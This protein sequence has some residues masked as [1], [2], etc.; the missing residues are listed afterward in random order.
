MRILCISDTVDPLVDSAGIRERFGDVDLVL[1]A[2]D[3]PL[4]YLSYVVTALNRPTLFVFGNH[5]LKDLPRYRPGS[6][7]PPRPVHEYDSD[8][9]ATYVG[10]KIRRE[11][12]M[13]VMGLGGSARYNDGP[14]QFSQAQMWARVIAKVPALILNRL[15]LG[16]AVDVVLTHAPPRGVHDKDDPCHRGFSAFLWLMSAF[17]PRYLVHG[18][19]HLYDAR[20]PRCS[21]YRDTTVVNAYGHHVLD[22]EGPDA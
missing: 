10:F 12:G 15:F 11:S 18:H 7:T 8:A 5:N 17:K 22:T 1:G 21:R 6:E 13:I 16:R 19:V 14:N 9:G 3:L 20:E 2:G 4:D